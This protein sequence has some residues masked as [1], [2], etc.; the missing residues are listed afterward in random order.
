MD[1]SCH[2]EESFGCTGSLQQVDKVFTYTTK[3][4]MA[5]SDK[6]NITWSFKRGVQ[7]SS[8][9]QVLKLGLVVY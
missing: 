4:Y 5:Q 6:H 3:W 7:S 8:L 2:E 9:K 1:N